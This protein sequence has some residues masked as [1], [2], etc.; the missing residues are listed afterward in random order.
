MS[1]IDAQLKPE[2]LMLH[3]GQVP[4]PTTGARVTPIYQQHRFVLNQR[5]MPRI[6]LP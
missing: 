3:G 4:D 1:Q 5:N 2:S 6:Y